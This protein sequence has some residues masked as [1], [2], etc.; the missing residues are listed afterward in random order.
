M[1]V[2]MVGHQDAV[3]DRA[4]SRGIPA[5][6]AHWLAG[7]RRAAVCTAITAIGIAPAPLP[8]GWTTF[9]IFGAAAGT[10]GA[11]VSAETSEV[12]ARP[13]SER[14]QVGVRGTPT[15]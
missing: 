7:L 2:E 11:C 10:I 4:R 5:F 15:R 1:A 13:A 6:I 14:S 8:V 3:A 9:A 12:G